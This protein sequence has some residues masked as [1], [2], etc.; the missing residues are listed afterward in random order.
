MKTWHWDDAAV[1][2]PP[3]RVVVMA[4]ENEA[5]RITLAELLDLSQAK[6]APDAET[7]ARA[8][9]GRVMVSTFAAELRV[10][11][12]GSD[13]PLTELPAG[14]MEVLGRAALAMW[15]HPVDALKSAFCVRF[16]AW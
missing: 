15:L 16:Y 2:T 6:C 10:P 12:G 7:Q 14:A 3:S 13:R 8:V 9:T 11:K 5:D 1:T 4:P